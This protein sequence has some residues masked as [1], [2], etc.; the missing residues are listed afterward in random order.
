LALDPRQRR[1]LEAA[2]RSQEGALWLH[3]QHARLSGDSTHIADL[4]RRGFMTAAPVA[5]GSVGGRWIITELGRIAL[6][7]E[8]CWEL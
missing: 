2:A 8:G 6:S 7:P 1:L 5:K 4:S 3:R